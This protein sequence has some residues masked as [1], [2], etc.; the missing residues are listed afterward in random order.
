MNVRN[1]NFSER[2]LGHT[3]DPIYVVTSF[4]VN[5]RATDMFSEAIAVD[6][7]LDGTAF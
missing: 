6:I 1:E 2:N 5:Q 3:A 7:Q 4:G